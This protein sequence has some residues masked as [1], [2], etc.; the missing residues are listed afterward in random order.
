M[1]TESVT[2]VA[3]HWVPNLPR[4]H[5]SYYNIMFKSDWSASVVTNLPC[6][7]SNQAF[8]DRD[9]IMVH[10]CT[11]GYNAQNY[12]ILELQGVQSLFL[13]GTLVR[14]NCVQESVIIRAIYRYINYRYRDPKL[15]RLSISSYTIV[16]IEQKCCRY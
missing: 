9:V 3:V 2:R 12:I 10:R 1:I 13:H 14:Y 5:N 7:C 16:I 15:N 4:N 11:I 6:S 8:L